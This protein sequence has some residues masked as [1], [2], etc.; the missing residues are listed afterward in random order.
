MISV[1]VFQDT[2]LIEFEE[3]YSRDGLQWQVAQW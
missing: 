1:E 2:G 3:L